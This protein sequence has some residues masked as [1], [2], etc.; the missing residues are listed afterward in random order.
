MLV[1]FPN[2]EFEIKY[3][4]EGLEEEWNTGVNPI[5]IRYPNLQQGKYVF[6]AKYYDQHKGWIVKEMYQIAIKAPWYKSFWAFLMYIT[7]LG[8]IVFIIARLY[9]EK[10]LEEKRAEQRSNELLLKERDRIS[11]DL[12]DDIGSTLSSISIYNDLIKTQVSNN[13]TKINTFS[14][15]ISEQIKELMMNTEDIIWS[16]KIGKQGHQKIDKRIHEYAAELLEL[17]NIKL[18]IKISDDTDSKLQHPQL[19][20]N[21]LMI[22]KEA[23]NNASKY[24]QAEIFS[25][26]MT[27]KHNTLLLD[28][29]DDGI[30]FELEKT[31]LGD[32]VD[33][34]KNRCASM[35]GTCSINSEVNQGTQI[36]CRIPI[37]NIS[38]NS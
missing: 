33:N 30:G 32:G 38:A 16:L 8:G 1:E 19:R 27:V 13:T 35:N 21:V 36:C 37:A 3:Q 18:H 34:I 4:L 15:K 2:T 24:S 22:I 9:L 17:K 23:M 29:S 11:A 28:I 7:I 25:I 26:T 10:K 6:K 12:H 20:R 5:E 31:V 14:E